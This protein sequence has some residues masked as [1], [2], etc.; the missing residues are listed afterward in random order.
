MRSDVFAGVPLTEDA[1]EHL[2][3]LVRGLDATWRQMADRPEEAGADAKVEIVVPEGGGRARLSVD[4][5]AG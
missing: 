3:R 4:K 5:L 1:E 2:A